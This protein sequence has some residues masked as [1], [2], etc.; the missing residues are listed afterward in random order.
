MVLVA[1]GAR[2][3]F[4]HKKGLRPGECPELWRIYRP[5]D[6]V[7]VAKSYKAILTPARTWL[8]STFEQKR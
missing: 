1:D 7:D 2:G 5:G 6:V 4:L 8:K 3:A